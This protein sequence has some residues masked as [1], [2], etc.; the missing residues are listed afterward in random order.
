MILGVATKQKSD[1]SD[2]PE[3][4]WTRS[5]TQCGRVLKLVRRIA[6]ADAPEIA[7]LNATLLI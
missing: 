5:K 3:P 1:S 2:D 4:N 7:R 6:D